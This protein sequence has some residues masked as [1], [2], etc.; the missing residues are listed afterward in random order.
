MLFPGSFGATAHLVTILVSPQIYNY[1][2]ILLYSIVEYPNLGDRDMK[3]WSSALQE[4]L[5]AWD[6]PCRK[7]VPRLACKENEE[8]NKELNFTLLCSLYF[9]W[10][11]LGKIGHGKLLARGLNT[12]AWDGQGG[13]ESCT[14]FRRVGN[15]IDIFKKVVEGSSYWTEESKTVKWTK[16]VFSIHQAQ[17][18]HVP[19]LLCDENK[20]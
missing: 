13:L 19:K 10:L 12:G 6:P 3:D 4:F 7:V 20:S 5:T 16:A 15:K 1:S 11:S 9:L 8:A 18:S 17:L 2:C 14:L